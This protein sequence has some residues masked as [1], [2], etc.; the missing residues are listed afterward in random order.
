MARRAPSAGAGAS[1]DVP[2]RSQFKSHQGRDQLVFRDPKATT[3]DRTTIRQAGLAI[4]TEGAAIHFDAVLVEIESQNDSSM[5]QPVVKGEGANFIEPRTKGSFGT[6]RA[7]GKKV[8]IPCSDF[9]DQLRSLCPVG[10]TTSMT[11]RRRRSFPQDFLR[12]LAGRL[13]GAGFFYFRTGSDSYTTAQ[14]SSDRK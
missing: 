13:S 4:A 12:A 10:L 8:E 11:G 5:P 6:K 1:P 9:L 3:D 14:P 2:Q 7:V